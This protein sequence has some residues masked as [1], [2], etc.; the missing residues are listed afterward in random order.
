MVRVA[1]FVAHDEP[2]LVATLPERVKE[3]PGRALGT[4]GEI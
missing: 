1:A 4:P 2:A 3:I